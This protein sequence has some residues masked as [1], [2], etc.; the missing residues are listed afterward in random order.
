MNITKQVDYLIIGAG[1][2]GLAIAR[3][4]KH[5]FPAARVLIIEK[6]DHI[7][8]HGSGRNSGVLH[9]G[10]YYSADSLKARFCREGNALMK[11]YVTARNLRLRP[12]KKVVV[13]KNETEWETLHELKRRGDTNGVDVSIVDEQ[14]LASIEPNA[15]TYREALYS[16]TTATVDPMEI[17]RSLTHHLQES[18][19]QIL[20]MHPYRERVGETSIRAGNILIEAA[21]IF[22]CAGLYADKVARDFGAG[23]DYTIIPFKGL[24]L[25]YTKRDAPVSTLIYPVPNLNNP[26][27]GVHFNVTAQ[28]KIKLGPT[29]IPAFWRENYEG[30]HGFQAE[31]M[32]AILAWETKLLA[33]DAFGFRRLAFEEIRKYS[34]RHLL[35]LARPM[36]KHLDESGFTQ[37]ARP[38]IRAQLLHKK[39]LELVQ[40]FIVES[41]ESGSVHILNAVSPGFT[42]SFAFARWIV[43]KYT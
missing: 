15:A 20:L 34:R 18:G 31:E 25:L 2:I 17:C 35:A 38:G 23:L 32:A 8:E 1:I 14:Q 13:A 30:I 42:S 27:L 16:P 39:R 19:V 28:G 37:W 24:H 26:F 40:D 43:E 41:G 11:E 10:F 12:T 21:K 6:E 33:T 5:R 4:L 7:A 36:V 3:E 9:A 29:A 22:N